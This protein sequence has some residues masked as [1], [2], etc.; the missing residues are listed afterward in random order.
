MTKTTLLGLLASLAVAQAASAI[1]ASAAP[2]RTALELKAEGKPLNAGASVL[3]VAGYSL[4][5]CYW[6]E[7]EMK[8]TVN[9]SN[10]DKLVRTGET[11]QL[12]PCG[13]GVRSLEITSTR[14]MIV[15][16]APLRIHLPRTC[17]YEFREFSGTFAQRE[18]GP[19]IAGTATGK[20]DR[21][22]S[23]R[24]VSCAKTDSTSFD[25]ALSGTETAA[26]P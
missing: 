19:E 4:G 8:V 7:Q 3:L 16:L 22:Q 5:G 24:S 20:L 2:A 17:V 23:T 18:W 21:A 10:V 6:E 13:G 26:V 25:V 15:K 14:K 11:G 1:W 12:E 9:R